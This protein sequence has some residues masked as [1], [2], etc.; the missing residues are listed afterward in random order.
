M[1]QQSENDTDDTEAAVEIEDAS[2]KATIRER[3]P[4]DIEDELTD[5]A[6]SPG[7]MRKLLRDTYYLGP[8][9]IGSGGIRRVFGGGKAGTEMRRPGGALYNFPRSWRFAAFERGLKTGLIT[10]VGNGQFAATERGGGLLERIDECPDCGVQRQPHMKHSVYVGNPNT[11]G[12]IE[13]H[14]LLTACPECGA[15]GYNRGSQQGSVSYERFD[16]D[17]EALE[18]AQERIADTPEAR[19]YGGDREVDSATVE[20]VPNVD[21]S[22]IDDVLAEWVEDHTE[23][24]VRDIFGDERE[25]YTDL[26]DRDVE[27]VDAEGGYAAFHGGE[28]TVTV[29]RS[30]E[31]GDCHIVVR[32]VS[33]D[34]PDED[35][36]NVEMGFEVA[37]EEGAKD[38]L[39]SRSG[40]WDGDQWHINAH[41]LGECI[42]ALTGGYFG[43]DLTVTVTPEAVDLTVSGLPG[44]VGAG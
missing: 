4:T 14:K 18:V 9:G 7:R 20:K 39:K 6:F 42:S 24:T 15:N 11:E 22:E 31:E 19:T 28:E 30:D 41:R 34:S 25:S 10:H 43:D 38:A 8:I 23:P 17:D 27:T 21:K 35:R 29:T 12:H 32:H 36:F 3:L 26:Y 13:S 1:T 37:V 40:E 2:D 5:T 33:D 44:G 16:R